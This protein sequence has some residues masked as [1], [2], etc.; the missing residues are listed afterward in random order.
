VSESS[1]IKWVQRFERSGSRAACKMGGY[2]RLRLEPHREFLEPLRAERFD[3]T[4]KA[5]RI[6][7]IARRILRVARPNGRGSSGLV[8]ELS[9][10]GCQIAYL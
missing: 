5:L 9:H 10:E 6:R 3:I 1:A 2:P 7:S 4:L 8:A